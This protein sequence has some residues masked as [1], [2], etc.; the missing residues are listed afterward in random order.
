MT[1]GV[2]EVHL[3]G[4]PVDL[5]A[6]ASSHMKALQREFDLLRWR[7][8]DDTSIPHRLHALIEEL[9]AQFGGVGDQPSAELEEAASRGEVSIDLRYRVPHAAGEAAQRLRDLLDEVD[10]YCR[11]GDYLLTLVTPADAR[12]YRTWFLSEFSRQAQ[13]EAPIPWPDY[14]GESTDLRRPSDQ[15]VERAVHLPADWSAIRDDGGAVIVINGPLDLEAAPALRDALAE[16]ILEVSELTVDL[17][18]CDFLDS[19]GVSVLLAGLGRAQEAGVDLTFRLSEAAFRVIRISGLLDR[20]HIL[21]D[22]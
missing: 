7:D 17:R 2:I 21:S 11:A 4:L 15:P 13:G 20:L 6:R 8:P 19:V 9:E 12:R 22:G 18:G 10:A 3:V 16:L 5:H 14:G 1:D